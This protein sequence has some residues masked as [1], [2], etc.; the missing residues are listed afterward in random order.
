MFPSPPSGDDNSANGGAA[1][2]GVVARF[3]IHCAAQRFPDKVNQDPEGALKLNVEATKNLATLAGVKI[4]N[5]LPIQ[6]TS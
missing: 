5:I 4:S 3:I 6:R 2:R 1:R